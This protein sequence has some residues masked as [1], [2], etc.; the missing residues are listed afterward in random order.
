MNPEMVG[1]LALAGVG[2]LTLASSGMASL[3]VSRLLKTTDELR[4]DVKQHGERLAAMEVKMPNGEW[5]AIK[6]GMAEVA[7]EI[8]ETR[9]ELSKH[10]L[11]ESLVM[12]D[13]R[14]MLSGCEVYLKR[15]AKKPRKVKR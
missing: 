9:S 3:G 11:D 8:R 14:G 6:D 12:S 7:L 15:S 2:L 13:M 4:G 5:R 10:V 1:Q